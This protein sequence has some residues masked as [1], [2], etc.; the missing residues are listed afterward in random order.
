[1]KA[2][3]ISQPHAGLV[4]WR[5]KWVENRT[6]ATSYRGLLAIHAGK[7]SKYLT[8]QELKAYDTGAVI[9]TCK[10][11]ECVQLDLIRNDS[12]GECEKLKKCGID[13]ERFLA[14]RY[15][16]G[17]Y[18]FILRHVLRLEKPV[19]AVGK[20]KFWEWEEKDVAA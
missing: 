1:M 13:I 18:C 8:S 3:T 20:Q 17:P 6:W 4:A 11:I 16:E 7:E 19:P 2:L 9:A 10:L 12:P 14:H 5:L 15:T